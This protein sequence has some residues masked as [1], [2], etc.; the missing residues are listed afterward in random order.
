MVYEP[1]T[2]TDG[3]TIIAF[4]TYPLNK[5]HGMVAYSQGQV[6]DNYVTTIDASGVIQWT[7]TQSKDERNAQVISER[8][9]EWLQS[10]DLTKAVTVDYQEEKEYWLAI[11]KEILVY[12]Y[13]NGTFFTLE[14]PDN[15]RTLTMY[16]GNIYM[17][18]DTSIMQFSRNETTYAGTIIEAEWHGGFYD[19]E[20]E[21]KRKTMRIL[22]ATIKP[23][24]KTY[25]SINYISDRNVGMTEREIKSQTYSYTLR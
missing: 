17:G 23:D 24:I 22:W 19:F 15:V 18:T 21:Y 13:S 9:N 3:N 6:L 25:M 10:R 4:P 20:R 11:G 1:V 2:D 12:N 16:D 14:L 5:S 8:V 7:N